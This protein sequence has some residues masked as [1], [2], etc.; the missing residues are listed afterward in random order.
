MDRVFGYC[1]LDFEAGEAALMAAVSR[2]PVAVGI[3][4]NKVF[5]LYASGIIS[6]KDCGPAPH[7]AE[8]EIMAI[9]HA[10]VVTGWGEE[11]V[12]GRAMKYWIL[13][14]SFGEGWGENGYFKLERGA[15]TLDREGF[16][17]CGM[18]FESVYPVMDESAGADACVPGSTFRTKYYSAT[19]A[20]GL[21]ADFQAAAKAFSASGRRGAAVALVGFGFAGGVVAAV[22]TVT[23]ARIQRWSRRASEEG[24][25]LLPQ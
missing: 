12:G 6:S 7:T 24:A 8:M 22:M 10:V 14:N 18:Y 2:H 3:N 21:G 9:N 4:A 20:A 19:S 13:K 25:A 1:E 17:T 15:H 5:Q 11:M 23:A 16:G